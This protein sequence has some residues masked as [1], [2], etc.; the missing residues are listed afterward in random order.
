[1]EFQIF[2]ISS[3]AIQNLHSSSSHD[4]SR[5]NQNPHR[6][7]NMQRKG[8]L[9]DELQQYILDITYLCESA[10]HFEY[11]YWNEIQ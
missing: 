6:I 9:D 11:K 10:S 2:F 7:Q 5:I 3:P 4:T 1:M 8:I